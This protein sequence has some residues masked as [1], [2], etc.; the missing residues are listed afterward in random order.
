MGC[1]RGALRGVQCGGLAAGAQRAPAACT[2]T[3]PRAAL[4]SGAGARRAW[5]P[6]W[7]ES[8]ES[9]QQRPPPVVAEK[10]WC[11]GVVSS[12]ESSSS[13]VDERV[14]CLV[15]ERGDKA[16]TLSHT[17][18]SS[19]FASTCALPTRLESPQAASSPR[20]LQ[21]PRAAALRCAAPHHVRHRHGSLRAQ[22]SSSSSP[23]EEPT[24]TASK[25]SA[26]KTST[27]EA[28]VSEFTQEVCR[29]DLPCARS[30]CCVTPVSERSWTVL[31]ASDLLNELSGAKVCVAGAT[32]GVGAEVVKTLQAAGVPVVALVRDPSRANFGAGVEVIKGDVYRYESLPAAVQGCGAVICATGCR[33]SLDPLGP[34][35]TDYIGTCNL[36]AAAKNAGVRK[37]V[38][39]TSIGADEILFPLNL[40]WGVLFWKKQA[41]LELQR[42]GLNYTIVRPG[43]LKNAT[44]S[45]EAPGPVQMK[46]AGTFGLP[47]KETSGSIL[48]S[49]VAEVCVTA[50]KTKEADNKVVE[51]ISSG[52][53]GDPVPPT[54]EVSIE[55]LFAG[56]K[57]N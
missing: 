12:F 43:G 52:V 33:P 6:S 29:R 34:F 9:T 47:P 22:A 28:A 7:I 36:V 4:G 57:N 46:P 23:E 50:L 11:V 53:R 31:Q 2:G 41:E 55:S 18:M 27:I 1:P 21:I 42:S 40:A 45:G 24:K 5:P 30:L 38:F 16:S 20:P 17:P 56:I 49:Q 15:D 51:V 25:S 32:G 37:F 26:K 10:V 44:D 39:V 54:A 19:L 48:R 35:N 8:N 3:S 13:L 14:H